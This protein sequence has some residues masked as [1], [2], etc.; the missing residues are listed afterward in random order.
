M[1]IT[2]CLIALCLSS[3]IF[4]AQENTLSSIVLPDSIQKQ[5][6]A[7]LTIIEKAIGDLNN[8]DKKD[9]LVVLEDRKNEDVSRKLMVFTSNANDQYDLTGQSDKI[10]LC[11]NCG[12]VFGDPHE[13]ILI[14]NKKIVVMNYGGS[15]YRWSNN[16]TFSWSRID[17]KWQLILWENSSYHTS[18]P[19]KIKLIKKLPKNFGKVNLEDFNPDKF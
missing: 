10:I 5:L 6:P 19:N 7:N 14:K 2:A 8:D 16:Y 11:K 17:S 18:N 13:G 4:A 12:G 1:K 9:Y 15:N 3:S